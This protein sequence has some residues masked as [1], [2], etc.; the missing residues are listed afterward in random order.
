MASFGS[1]A[2]NLQG[3]YHQLMPGDS[4]T[5]KTNQAASAKYDYK[6][7]SATVATRPSSPAASPGDSAAARAIAALQAQLSQGNA[8]LAATR[9]QIAAMPKL[10]S[11]DYAGSYARAGQMAASTVNPV[12]TDK[13]NR[14]LEKNA[15]ERGQQTT[16]RTRNKEDIATAL[17]QAL[18]DSTDTRTRTNEDVE[19]LP[20]IVTWLLRIKFVAS[21]TKSVTLKSSRLVRW[22]ISIRVK[23]ARRVGLPAGLRTKTSHSATSSRTRILRKGLLALTWR[24]PVLVK[25][26]ARLNQLSRVYLHRRLPHSPGLALALRT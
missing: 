6:P 25:L 26:I 10:P 24:L 21:P 7:P 5:Y 1:V 16:T 23:L 17:A 19:T 3:V 12:Y 2:N 15:A 18:Q 11:F 20:L 4:Q 8:A 13:L 14:Y 9:A 22:L